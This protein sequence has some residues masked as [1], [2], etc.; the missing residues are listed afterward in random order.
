[1]LLV[2]TVR[3]TGLDGAMSVALAPWRKPRAVHDPGKILLDVALAVALGGGCPADVGMLRADPAVFGPV[4]SDGLPP[5]CQFPRIL[6][7]FLCSQPFAEAGSVVVFVV[8]WALEATRAV[9][10]SGVVE[11][12]DPG[13]NPDPGLG[14]GGEGVPMDVLDLQDAVERLADGEVETRSDSAYGLE[15]VQRATKNLE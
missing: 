11:V 12:G 9:S 1:M 10:P 7:T 5:D 8:D 14:V 6:E 13:G 2:E 4:A 15:D 3:K